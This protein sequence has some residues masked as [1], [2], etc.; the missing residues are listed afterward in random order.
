MKLVAYITRYGCWNWRLLP[1]FA[2][3]ARCG[4][5]CR[6]RWMNY[7]RPDIKR[8]N[9]TP[10]EDDT[11]ITLHQKL[12]NK[13][14]KIAACLPGRTDNEIKNHWHTN[15]KKRAQGNSAGHE[16]DK[17]FKSKDQIPLESSPEICDSSITICTTTAPSSQCDTSAGESQISSTFPVQLTDHAGGFSSNN[18]NLVGEDCHNL[19]TPDAFVETMSENFWTE[20]YMVDVSY[21]PNEEFLPLSPEYE[22]NAQLWEHSG[23][24]DEYIDL[25]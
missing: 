1:K 10:L 7:L 14:S 4:K 8:G 6:L 19:A 16:K 9:Y 24:H 13:W 22:Y 20:P 5:S 21:V 23:S 12:G 15:L 11:I 17:A 3:L 18:E 25:S 2:G